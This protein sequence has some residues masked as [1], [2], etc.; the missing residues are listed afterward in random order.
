M[1]IELLIIKNKARL[2]KMIRIGVPQNKILLQ[3][4]K[5]DKLLNQKLKED[6]NIK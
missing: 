6:S 3:S 5:V 1:K 4:K 2:E